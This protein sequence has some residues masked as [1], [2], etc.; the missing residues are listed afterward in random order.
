MCVGM[1]GEGWKEEEGEERTGRRR[2]TLHAAQE[3][4]YM[5]VKGT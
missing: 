5:R 1:G 3:H 2:L 4:R